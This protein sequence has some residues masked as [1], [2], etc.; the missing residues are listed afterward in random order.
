MLG[1]STAAL[2][3]V[4]S[5]SVPAT[6][7]RLPVVSQPRTRHR[8]PYMQQPPPSGGGLGGRSSAVAAQKA[9]EML[10]K[11]GIAAAGEMRP[12]ERPI[13]KEFT[14]AVKIRHVRTIAA[15]AG[16]SVADYMRLPVDQYAIYDPRLMRR[17]PLEEAGDNDTFELTLPTMRPR[18]GTYA[19]SPKLRLR[20]LPTDESISIESISAS[21]FG[22]TKP[23]LL[24]ANA[25][26]TAEQL[27]AASEEMKKAFNL[28]FNTTLSWSPSRKRSAPAGTTD[29]IATTRVKL[30]IQLP[31][32]FTRA[33]RLL[34]QGAIGIIMRFVGNAILPRFAS[35]LETDYQKWCNGTRD[36]T[37]GFGSLTLSE[38]GYVVVP[39]KMLQ[40]MRDAQD[41]I[42]SNKTLSSAGPALVD[43]PAPI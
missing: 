2:L 17:L 7:L 1:T 39:D 15:E 3:L 33:P 8:N 43:G 23:D 24:P 21:L 20:V 40:E 22:D 29:V 42:V 5:W 32:P 38:D 36:L 31:P 16:G 35:L 26:V 30:R 14:S 6:A 19:P 28:A 12:G 9:M 41:T 4:T 34:V 13:T 25:T 27:D 18:P 37:T 10:G 11:M